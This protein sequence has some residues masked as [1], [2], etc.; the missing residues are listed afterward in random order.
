MVK[1]LGIALFLVLILVGSFFLAAHIQDNASARHLVEQF[2]YG[3][4]LL[5]SIIAGLNL[6]VPIPA[7]AFTPIY[8]A[9]GFPLLLIILTITIGTTIGDSISYLI[10]V[11]GRHITKHAHPTLQTKMQSFAHRHHHL[12]LPLVFLYSAFSPF[13]NEL[14]LIPLAIIGIRYRVLLVPLLF[15]TVVYETLFAYGITSAF[16]YFF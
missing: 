1:I 14:I 6:F 5:I 12:V 8:V 16:H 15:G 4:I 10:G 3:G 13:P 2:G 7:G 9:A 11:G